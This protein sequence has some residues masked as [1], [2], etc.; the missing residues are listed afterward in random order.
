MRWDERVGRRIKLRDLHLLE[1]AARTGSLAK[2]AKS[3]GMSQPAVSYAIAEMERSLAVPLLDRTSQGVVPTAF[4]HALLKRS[5]V[6]FNEIRHGLSEIESLADP[7]RGELRLGTPQPMLPVMSAI[8]DR[9]SSQYPNITFHLTV[10]STHILLRDLRERAVELVISRMLAPSVDDDLLIDILFK[11]EL[12]VIAGKNNPWTK[13]KVVRLEQLMKERW[14]LPPTDGWLHP[15][16]QKAFGGKG[17]EVPRATV[18]TL[19]TYAVSMLVAQGPFLTVHPETMLHVA[20]ENRLLRALPVALPETRTPVGLISM[21]HHT[22]SP[23][24]QVFVEAARQAVK[25]LIGAQRE[26]RRPPTT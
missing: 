17:L 4:G 11:D 5:A 15:L 26:R 6:V 19:S 10:E 9:V 24:A 12:A 25:E 20:G 7:T 1:A 18:S 22:L 23:T 14:V 8:I 3:L 2:A 21:K 16:M 13:R